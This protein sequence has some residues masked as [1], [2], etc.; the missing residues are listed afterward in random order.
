VRVGVGDDELA[1]LGLGREV[2]DF[3]GEAEIGYGVL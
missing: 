1:R 3:G 2:D